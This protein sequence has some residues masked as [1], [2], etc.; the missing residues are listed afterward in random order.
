[1]NNQKPF[2]NPFISIPDYQINYDKI[3]NHL[4][5]LEKDIKDLDNRISILEQTKT[6]SNQEEP[7]DMYMI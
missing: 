1:M 7:T 3:I 2:F 4:S 6:T 5:K